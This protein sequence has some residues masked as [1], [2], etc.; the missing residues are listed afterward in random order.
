MYLTHMGRLV[1]FLQPKQLNIQYDT[2]L[3]RVECRIS[4][5]IVHMAMLR[6]LYC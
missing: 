3:I 2:D 5:S 4:I 6:Y 1:D